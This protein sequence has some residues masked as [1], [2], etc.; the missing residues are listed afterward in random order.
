MF[1]VGND[2]QSWPTLDCWLSHSVCL[3]RKT[4]TV[5]TNWE[6]DRPTEP[7]PRLFINSRRLPCHGLPESSWLTSLLVWRV[8]WRHRHSAVGLFIARHQYSIIGGASL[9][10]WNRGLKQTLKNWVLSSESSI[11]YVRQWSRL[12]QNLSDAGHAW[13]HA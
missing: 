6:G 8:R 9:T 13:H 12:L 4:I 1:S 10:N 2:G 5:Y 3:R 11:R 7:L